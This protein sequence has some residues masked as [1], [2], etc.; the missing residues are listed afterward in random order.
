MSKK[1]K[2]RIFIVLLVLVIAWM[3]T[4]PV[5]FAQ[6]EMPNDLIEAVNSLRAIHGLEPYQIDPWLM[7]YAQEHS[8]YQAKMQSGTHLHS[9]GTLPWEIGLQENVAGGDEGIVTVSI[10]VYEI[11]V[12]WGHRHVLT[13]YT[14]GE[15]GAGMARGENGQIYYTVDIRPAQGA[16]TV[17]P[18]LGTEEPFALYAT[19]TPDAD[20]AIYHMVGPGQSLWSIAV[21]YGVTVNDIRLLNGIPGDSIVIQV[22]KKLLIRPASA[23][24]TAPSVTRTPAATRTVGKTYLLLTAT[25]TPTKTGLPSPTSIMIPTITDKGLSLTGRQISGVV[26]L[27]IAVIGF[28]L[29]IYFGFRRK[30]D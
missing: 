26:G 17:V 19:S 5:T 8:E 24:T 13:G 11:W 28:I 3:G 4:S 14:R 21:S 1:T 18:E 16:P 23:I 10:V 30:D 22:G 29:V 20:G 9:D 6:A 27:V 15:I 7:A 2:T 25:K 12:D